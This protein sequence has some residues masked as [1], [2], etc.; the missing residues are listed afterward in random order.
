M[1]I[2]A[3]ISAFIPDPDPA[4]ASRRWKEW[5]TSLEFYFDAAEV[6]E[7]RK[8]PL[9][10]HLI[11]PAMQTVYKSSIEPTI[12]PPLTYKSVAKAITSHLEPAI[13][14]EFELYRFRQARQLDGESMDIY[15]ARL[16]KLAARCCFADCDKEIKSQIIASCRDSGLRRR[17][18]RDANLDL[19][20][21]LTLARTLEMTEVQASAIEKGLQTINIDERR[22]E[23]SY[24]V[25]SSACP[26]CRETSFHV[27]S[28]SRSR[29]CQN[30]GGHHSPDR[31]S[32]PA[33]GKACR[34]CQ[35]LDHFESVCRSRIAG[36]PPTPVH[37]DRPR[38]RHD[39]V[40][41]E[42]H[43][44]QRR[45][46]SSRD[47]TNYHRRD[48]HNKRAYNLLHARSPSL[49][50]SSS[51]AEYEPRNN[52]FYVTVNTN[53]VR[54]LPHTKVYIDQ[55]QQSVDMVID[56]GSSV[57]II[58]EYDYRRLSPR[59]RLQQTAINVHAY[60]AKKPLPI[61]G[62]FQVDLPAVDG[63]RLIDTRF[64][65]TSGK[66]HSTSLLS[67]A[68]ASSIGLVTLHQS[69]STTPAL[70]RA[71]RSHDRTPRHRN[72]VDHQECQNCAYRHGTNRRAC[73]PAWGQTCGHC[74]KQNHFA[75]CCRSRLAGKPQSPPR[76]RRRGT[77]PSPPHD[78]ARLDLPL[79]RSEA[80]SLLSSDTEHPPSP[81][82]RRRHHRQRTSLTTTDD[83]EH[84]DHPTD[85]AP[86]GSVPTDKTDESSSDSELSSPALP[87]ASPRHQRRRKRQGRPPATSH[88]FLLPR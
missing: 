51:E 44:R 84:D 70:D 1:S 18:L 77:S 43:H 35:K 79:A 23:S 34:H 16:R 59:P 29:A 38:S 4:E 66:A 31:N 19:R 81:P 25:D 11:G 20:G 54:Q 75:I 62:T 56:T 69:A 61:I 50:S 67:F 3:S 15:A 5:L 46:S 8:L 86:R 83:R 87:S 63:S 33:W 55:Q 78:R 32:C 73:C 53:R 82:R 76:P 60:G 14:V 52:V 39:Q 72:D 48:D 37:H 71:P 2:P 57:N 26:N 65:V 64:Y 24:H 6:Q 42:S 27:D 74:R 68:T 9:L 85:P 28:S 40:N 45:R 30:C 88:G 49:S 22:R 41:R 80:D 58:C 10:L 13:N 36:H 12:T 7:A 21:L 47:R 17:A